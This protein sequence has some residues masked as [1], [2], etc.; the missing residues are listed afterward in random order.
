MNALVALAVPDPMAFLANGVVVLFI[1]VIIL[2]LVVVFHHAFTDRVRRRNRLR[3]E[4]AAL[5]LAPDL[6]STTRSI[7]RAVAAARLAAGDRAVALVLRKMRYDVRGELADRA[8][9]VLNEMGE[10]RRLIREAQSPREWKRLS[11]TRALGECGGT[12]AR[13]TLIE[14]ASS[15]KSDEVRFAAMQGLLGDGAVEAIDAAVDAFAGRLPHRAGA[16]NGFYTRLASVSEER[17]AALVRS[18]RLPANEQKLALEAAG[19]VGRRSAVGLAKE[20]LMSHDAEMRATAVRVVGKAGGESELRLVLHALDDGEWFVR[21]AAARSLDWMLLLG[22]LRSDAQRQ[23]ACERLSR[24]LNDEAWWVRAN[25]ARAL[26]H[27]GSEGMEMLRQAV[28]SDDAFARE[29]AAAA[30]AMAGPQPPAIATAG[31]PIAVAVADDDDEL[32]LGERT[33]RPGGRRR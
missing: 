32:T 33:F 30:Q 29:T 7:D 17:M 9:T 26:A 24:H 1:V 16:R 22:N 12:R 8:S 23:I 14:M 3:F 15:D 19:D 2:S 21:A 4:S 20:H 11:A 6:V 13:K 28:L 31:P 5:T 10:V 18:E 27:A 25:C